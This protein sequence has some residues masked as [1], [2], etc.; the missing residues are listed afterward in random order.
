MRKLII[1]KKGISLR[2]ISLLLVFAILSVTIFM[3]AVYDGTKYYGKTIS[4]QHSESF[5]EINGTLAKINTNSKDL[6]NKVNKLVQTPGTAIFFVP[7][8][9]IDSFLLSFNYV[10]YIWNIYAQLN[11]TLGIS[12]YIKV[13]LEIA[14]ILLLCYLIIDA[15][16]RYKKT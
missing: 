3:N 15:F 14:I 6:N 1:G 8:I 10:E 2:S 4:Q 16:M 7:A 5:E 11:K 13:S 9:I 12:D